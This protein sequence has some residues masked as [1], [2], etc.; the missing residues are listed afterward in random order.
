MT[1]DNQTSD[2]EGSGTQDI[3]PCPFCG[4]LHSI[5]NIGKVIGYDN[6]GFPITGNFTFAVKTKCI[7]TVTHIQLDIFN[8][9]PIEDK[10][11]LEISK[12]QSENA[13]LK[14][15]KE[16]MIKR[17]EQLLQTIRLLDD[18]SESDE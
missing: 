6:F 14:D 7:D 4:E 16:H 5:H 13:S 1:K 8:T 9:R 12:L 18:D 3:K 11:H 15:Q 10:L 17:I 2:I